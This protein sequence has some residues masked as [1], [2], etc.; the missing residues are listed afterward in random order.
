MQTESVRIEK[1]IAKECRK[2]AQQEGRMLSAQLT[3]IIR[4]GLEVLSKQKDGKK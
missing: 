1:P 2:I 3:I 4:L